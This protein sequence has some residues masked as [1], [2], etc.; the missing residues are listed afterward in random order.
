MCPM[1][2]EEKKPAEN[3][4]PHAEEKRDASGQGNYCGWATS[5]TCPYSL[6]DPKPKPLCGRSNSAAC[7]YE[8]AHL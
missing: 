6:G 5:A 3:L 2:E 7:G 4:E 1:S 8:L